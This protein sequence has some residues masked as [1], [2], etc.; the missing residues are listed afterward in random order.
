MR[1][2]SSSQIGYS[3]RYLVVGLSTTAFYFTLIY[4]FRELLGVDSLGAVS[5]AYISAT[6]FNLLSNK[7]FTFSYQG[8]TD[9]ALLIRYS[10]L[11]ILNYFAQLFVIWLTFSQ[12]HFNFYISTLIS[13]ATAMVLGFVLSKAWVFKEQK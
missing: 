11:A 6:V 4:V 8:K 5:I 2:L 3:F 1:L 12:L 10:T 7:F 9:S 13:S